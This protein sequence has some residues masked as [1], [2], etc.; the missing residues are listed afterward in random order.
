M[1]SGSS[2]LDDL[3]DDKPL[4][5]HEGLMATDTAAFSQSLIAREGVIEE[6]TPTADTF[7]W[8][9]PTRDFRH[10]PNR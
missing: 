6:V 1:R 7:R 10:R 4:L 8:S 3:G 9:R 2:V 5:P